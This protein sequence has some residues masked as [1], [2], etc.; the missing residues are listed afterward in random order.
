MA[1]TFRNAVM[2]ANRCLTC[3]QCWAILLGRRLGVRGSACAGLWKRCR[4]DGEGLGSLRSV[5]ILASRLAQRPQLPLIG[6]GHLR[7]CI[8]DCWT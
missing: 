6:M 4:R 8:A 3:Y 1:R 2:F 7:R 5:R